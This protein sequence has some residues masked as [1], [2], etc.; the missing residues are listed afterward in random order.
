[1][2]EK[3]Y[4][5][6]VVGA[7][8]VLTGDHF[9]FNKGDLITLKCDDG[10]N[11]PLFETTA[12]TT[13]CVNMAHVIKLNSTVAEAPATYISS[14][15]FAAIEVGDKL[16]LRT[17]LEIGKEYGWF[18]WNK[19]MQELAERGISPTVE[20][21]DNDGS[22]KACAED[23]YWYYTAEMIAEVIKR[24]QP[25]FAVGDI[26]IATWR[27]DSDWDLARRITSV[28]MDTGE[29]EMEWADGSSLRINPLYFSTAEDH[30]T[31]YKGEIPV[32]PAPEFDC[33]ELEACKVYY[34]PETTI[35]GAVIFRYKGMKGHSVKFAKVYT[36]L[37]TPEGL[38]VTHTDV[39]LTEWREDTAEE[40]AK[41]EA[42]E[43]ERGYVPP[44]VNKLGTVIEAGKVYA[45]DGHYGEKRIF[46]VSSVGKTSFQKESN[47]T[48]PTGEIYNYRLETHIDSQSGSTAVPATAEQIAVFEAAVAKD[49]AEK[50]FESAMKSLAA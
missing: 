16:K 32:E 30:L 11:C 45:S 26:V 38:L 42:A 23:D 21:K 29:Y 48:L 15:E 43:K 20:R 37:Y 6:K 7:Q 22:V 25:K 24:E 36:R 40:V 31:Y 33:P 50:A 9:I 12:G 17:D 44:L 39:E 5:E 19:N 4:A 27:R 14:E 3:V 13:W 2:T 35:A 28:N 46:K 47:F 8:Y 18:D 34:R 49:K 41:L 10:T 1:M